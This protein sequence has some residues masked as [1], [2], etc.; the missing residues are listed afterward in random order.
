MPVNESVLM[1]T[2]TVGERVQLHPATDAW[3]RGER[4]ANVV[5]IIPTSPLPI[6]VKTDHGSTIHFA[7]CNVMALR[8]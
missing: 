3:M 4:Y 5:E 6:V 8:D 2:F 7:A 1:P